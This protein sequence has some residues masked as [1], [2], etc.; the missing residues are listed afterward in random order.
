MDLLAAAHRHIEAE[1][2]HS[3]AEMMQT[4]ADA[5]ADYV[6]FP[7]DQQ[8]S[9]REAIKKFYAEIAY[10]VPDMHVQVDNIFQDQDTRQVCVQYTFT[11]THKS[12]FW[13]LAPTY[14]P[15]KYHG[16]IIYAFDATGKL[17]KEIGYFD[18]TEIL[19]SLGII[20]DTNTTLGQFLLIFFQSPIYTIKSGLRPLFVRQ[21]ETDIM[22]NASAQ[23]VW[24]ILT[25]FRE[26][27]DWN[28]FLQTV[29]G[30]P[31][32]GDEIKLL[33]VLPSGTTKN[34]PATILRVDAPRELRW[35]DGLTIPLPFIFQGEHYFLVEP[36]CQSK[37][38]FVHGEIFSG[39]AVPFLW[40]KLDTDGRQG[41]ENMNIALK[42]RAEETT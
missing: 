42:K 18:K 21:L 23:T 26:F 16:C 7:N 9:S 14:K 40:K 20:R 37:V 35:V 28:P 5:G 15:L 39:L 19:A 27:P 32:E 10:A 1:N 17:T 30:A 6:L 8:F 33:A 41:Y 34:V 22:I 29:Q 31:N 12:V 38:R 11:G 36:V 2:H 24:N 4:I 13:G 25:N 3:I